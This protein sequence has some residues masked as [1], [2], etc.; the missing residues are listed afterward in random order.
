MLDRKIHQARLAITKVEVN[1]FDQKSSL[2]LKGLEVE[3]GVMFSMTFTHCHT[4]RLMNL[5]NVLSMHRSHE[6]V[7]SY[8]RCHCGKTTIHVFPR[9]GVQ[10]T[11]GELLAETG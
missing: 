1:E 6:G 10:T 5:S 8:V 7:L 11:K 9:A 2:L 3:N 4:T